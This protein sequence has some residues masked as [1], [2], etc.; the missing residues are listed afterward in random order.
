MKV[1]LYI[2]SENASGKK[3]RNIV[4]SIVSIEEIEIFQTIDELSQRLHQ[5]KGYPRIAILM[6][7]NRKEL[8]AILSFS[9]LFWNLRIILVLPD[10]ARETVSIG[11]KLVPRYFS[12]SDTNLMDV[13][14]VLEKMLSMDSVKQAV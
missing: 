7:A 9:D 11:L 13:A 14:A 8:L 10:R 12:Y 1:L 5:L 6:P 3:L 2:S 4:E